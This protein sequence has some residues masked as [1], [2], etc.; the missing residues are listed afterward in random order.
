MIK[1]IYT[2][3]SS[4]CSGSCSRSEEEI[5]KLVQGEKE[6]GRESLWEEE[7]RSLDTVEGY[8]QS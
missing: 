6:V 2:N 1:E 8:V 4:T 3:I 5:G 7:R